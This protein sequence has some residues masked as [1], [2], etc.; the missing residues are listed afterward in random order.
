M[1]ENVRFD[2]NGT[3]TRKQ[4]KLNQL[5]YDHETICHF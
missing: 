1:I 5:E 4:K 3:Q 2:W